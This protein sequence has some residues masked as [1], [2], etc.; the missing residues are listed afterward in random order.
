MAVHPVPAKPTVRAFPALSE[1][2]LGTYNQSA[3]AWGNQ[4]TTYADGIYDLAVSAFDNATDA[5]DSALVARAAADTVQTMVSFKGLWG[6]LSGALARPATVIENGAYWMLLQDLPDVAAVRPGTNAAVWTPQILEARNLGAVN[7]DTVI[8]AGS[9]AV[10][11]A[12]T[13]APPG[14]TSALVNVTRYGA[15]AVQD[16]SDTVTGSAWRRMGAA[17][18]TAPAWTAWGR[19]S[20]DNTPAVALGGGAMDCSRGTCFTESVA[21]AR[22]LV[23]ASIP[24]G[25]YACVLEVYHTGGAITLPAGSVWVAGAPPILQT[26][27]RHLFFF[28]KAVTGSGGWIVSCLPNSAI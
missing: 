18:T 15:L 5:H 6:S 10:S 1:R 24:S 13:N 2:A 26:P 22:T 23:F 4:M 19:G 25:A 17:L 9:Y 16:L 7:L 27:R 11:G 8:N 28:Q 20:Q 3:Y 12:L 14:V 21:A